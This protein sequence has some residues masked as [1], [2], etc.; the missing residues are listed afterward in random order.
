MSL[1]K[2]DCWL[3]SVFDKLYKIDVV[4]YA[5]RIEVFVVIQIMKLHGLINLEY[6][7]IYE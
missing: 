4:H 2:V 7:K 6:R 3:E 1:I 5:E